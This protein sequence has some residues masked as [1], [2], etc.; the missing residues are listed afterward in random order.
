MTAIRVAHEGANY[1]VI[2]GDLADALPRLATVANGVRLPLI[3]DRR[4]YELHGAQLAAVSSG[5]PIFIPEGEA[6]KS[7]ATL[8]EV[9][10]QLGHAGV[11]RGTPFLALGGGS[12]GDVAGLAASLFKRGC[13]VVHVPTT[14]LAQADSAIGGKTAIDA[15]GQKNLVGTFHHP[16]LVLADPSLL[17][18]LDGR[19]LRSG[20]AE[21]VKYGMIDDPGFFAW[22]EA[23]GVGLLAGD[24]NAR[25]DAI[26][27]CVRAKTRFVGADPGDRTGT[28]ALLNFGHTF[29]HAIEALAGGSLLHGEAV[30][31]GMS[32]AFAFSASLHLCPPES[33]QRLRDHLA[34]VDLPITLAQAGLAG[35]GAD[36]MSLMSR[37]KKVGSDGLTLILARDIGQAFLQKGVDPGLL[38]GFLRDAP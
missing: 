37:D 16:T 1:D 28:R 8:S 32:L 14:L 5:D 20:Y 35:R 6:A 24:A 38:A 11:K 7:W 18:T 36:L 22:C 34:S 25:R 9:I 3:T 29:G 23:K 15:A 17:D 26:I 10:D 2:V 13:P 27:H 33:L 19:Q 21:V 30:A 4:V 12:V 31:I